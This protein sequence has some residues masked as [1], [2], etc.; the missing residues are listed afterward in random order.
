MEQLHKTIVRA[1]SAPLLFCILGGCILPA[2]KADNGGAALALLALAGSAS[3]STDLSCST[4]T[5]SAPSGTALADVVTSAP[6]ETSSGFGNS[7]CAVNG[8]RGEGNDQGSTDVFSLSATGTSAL[9]VLS[10]SSGKITNG[11]GVDFVVYE[12]PFNNNGSASNRFMEPIVVEVSYDASSWCG[13]NPAYSSGTYSTNPANWL[14]FAGLSP[15]L[16]NQDNNSL[17]A[18]SLF[19]SGG[20]DAFDLSNLVTGTSAGANCLSVASNAGCTAG[21]VSTLQGAGAGQGVR[22]I[23]LIAASACTNPNAGSAAFPQD[24][25]A[26]GGG[27]DIDGVIGRY[28]ASL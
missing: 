15:V 1:L 7:R 11:A 25:G 5:G 19:T 21:T 16:Y 12:N 23:R 9:I 27:P 20:G 2:G 8:V 10:F 18:G 4:R 17:N 26:F 13:F 14:R 28:P 24:S 6:G 3:S 22:Y